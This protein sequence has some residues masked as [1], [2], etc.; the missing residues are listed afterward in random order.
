MNVRTFAIVLLLL[1]LVFLIVGVLN[2]HPALFVGLA[3]IV[4]SGILMWTR[5]RRPGA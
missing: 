5:D 3:L 1:G 4:L 2:A